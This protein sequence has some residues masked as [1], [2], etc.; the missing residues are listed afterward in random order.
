MN[1]LTC[2][3]ELGSRIEVASASRYE[4]ERRQHKEPRNIRGQ[5]TKHE[6]YTETARS[7]TKTKLEFEE[8][9]EGL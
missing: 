3:E 7:G 4:F 2:S 9:G 8:C 5:R 6:Q 1:R